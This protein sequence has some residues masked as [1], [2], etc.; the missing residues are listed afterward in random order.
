MEPWLIAIIVLAGIAVIIA[1]VFFLWLFVL[2]R[3][4]VHKMRTAPNPDGEMTYPENFEELKEK[5]TVQKNLVYP[6]KYPS[7]KYNLYLPKNCNQK[8]PLIVWVHGGGFIGGS[9]DGGDNVMIAL[10]AAGYAIASID[11][12]VAPEHK[13][14]TAVRQ[15][16]DFVAHLKNVYRSNPTINEKKLIFGGDSA[17]AQIASQYI[18][19]QTSSQLST[20]MKIPQRIKPSALV[21][22]CGPFSFSSIRAYAAQTNKNLL[23]LID[24]WGRLYFGGIRWHQSKREQ[25]ANII[26]QANADFPPTF[27]TDGNKGSFETQNRKLADKLRSVSVPVEELYFDE[28]Y[29]EIPHEYLFHLHEETSQIAYKRICEFLEKI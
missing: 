18:A 15:V 9:K 6:S 20:E 7:N 28:S 25:Q 19:T 4:I 13:Y 12:A 23:R 3:V 29:G 14:P 16:S 1:L 22:V 24:I 17:G 26:L 5:V 27:L 2:P 21:L 11:Y 8:V 10:S